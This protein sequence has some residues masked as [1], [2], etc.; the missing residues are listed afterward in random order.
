MSSYIATL[1]RQVEEGGRMDGWMNGRTDG[2]MDGL[3]GPLQS[4]ET[5]SASKCLFFHCIEV[6]V[7]CENK[8]SI[9]SE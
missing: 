3:T 8:I 9:C 2:W 1:N 7:D 6:S 4:V 5:I